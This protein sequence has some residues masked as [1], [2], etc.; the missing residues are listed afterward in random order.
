MIQAT[1]A[2]NVLA[3]I[4]C[5]AALMGVG[6]LAF[7]LI[8][9]SMMSDL[10]LSPADAGFIASSNLVGYL[11]GAMLA[12]S[13][14][15]TGIERGVLI[16]VLALNVVLTGSMALDGSLLFL[17]INRFVGGMV[18]AMGMIFVTAVVSAKLVESK[19]PELLVHQFTGVGFG[20]VISSLA[21]AG[22]LAAGGGWRV[23]WL[24][25]GALALVGLILAVVFLEKGA[26]VR[27]RG[28]HEPPLPRSK[29]LRNIIAAYGLFGFGYIITTTFLIAIVR[30]NG[31]APR[32]EAIV[33]IITGLAVLPSTYLWGKLARKIGLPLT[34]AA[35]CFVEAIGVMAAVL[36]TGASGPLLGALLLGG[37]FVATT[38][39]G[40]Q[41][42]R[43]LAPNSPRKVLATMTTLLSVTQIFG[44]IVAGIIAAR[45]GGYLIASSIAAIIL[46]ASGLCVVR[47]RPTS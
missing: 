16:T 7:T 47:D 21:C 5:L 25:C 18:S 13:R 42:S 24:V 40:I 38:A 43:N 36:V 32:M 8:L 29:P 27:A 20:I 19:R 10:G 34:Y 31:D 9:P 12:S 28:D 37:T 23:C 45:S 17:S 3:G 1:P 33:W 11:L 15:F 14:I 39:L 4:C 30:D 44:P 6:R 22:V 2:R 35:G 46:V 41:Y 26:P